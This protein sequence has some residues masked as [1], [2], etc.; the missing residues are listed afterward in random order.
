MSKERKEIQRARMW[1]YFLDAATDVIDEEGVNNVTIRK[2]ADR[3][4]FTASTAYNYFKD[5]SHLKFFAAMRFTA[6]YLNELPEY[7][8][9]GS[10]TVENWLHSWE[11]FCKH[12]F[13][14]PEI[15]S[16]IFIDN[17]GT[18]PQ[19]LLKDYYEIYRKDLT[20]LPDEI[21]TIVME[22]NFSKRSA[23]YIEKA[24]EEGFIKQK[25]IEMIAE[26]TLMIWKGMMITYMNN[27]RN[28][29]QEEAAER[30]VE[31]V[32]ECVMNVVI[33]TRRTEVNFHS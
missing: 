12:S 4:G 25:D 30:T 19:E 17:L 15:Y 5:L 33:E 2:I 7:L 8:S 24:V 10:N 23:L 26:L 20:H 9:K 13:R 31:L 27:R 32:K 18:L 29:T 16:V 11:C 14:Q 28:Y 6:D 22:Q 21:Q 1:R 3:A